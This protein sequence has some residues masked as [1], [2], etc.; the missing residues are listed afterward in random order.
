MWDVPFFF[1]A[2][3]QRNLSNRTL[4]SGTNELKRN[5]NS[6]YQAPPRFKVRRFL[7]SYSNTL[8]QDFITELI[9]QVCLLGRLQ[10]ELH[11]RYFTRGVGSS[12]SVDDAAHRKLGSKINFPEVMLSKGK[13]NTCAILDQ[14]VSF[15]DDSFI[16]DTGDVILRWLAM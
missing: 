16:H 4:N 15:V 3:R 6:M 2:Y 5:P 12:T 14:P 1:L 13:V 7:C 8:S 9:G 10:I 11:M